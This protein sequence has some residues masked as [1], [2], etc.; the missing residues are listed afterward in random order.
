MNQYSNSGFSGW[1]GRIPT[2]VKNIILI[3]VIVYIVTFYLGRNVNY[4]MMSKYA[5]FPMDSNYFEPYQLITH[6]FM[7]GGFIHLFF[8]MYTFFFFGCVLE[9]VWGKKKFL[10]YYLITGL[11][12]AIC[13]LTV[14]HLMGEVRPIPTV[15][16]SGAV[17]GVLLGY[18]M[19]FPRNRITMLIP[20]PITLQA[21]WFVIIFGGIEL[22]LG[23]FQNDNV[24]HF[25]HLG[26]MLFGIILILLWKNKDTMYTEWGDRFE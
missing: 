17:Y 20:I 19:L 1:W 18:G 16:A 13:H 22:F 2:I 21:R 14:M 15:G 6:M 8:N 3:N 26:G 9:N 23:F 7:H 25:A 10:I 4:T 12:A 11:G 5:L 24:A